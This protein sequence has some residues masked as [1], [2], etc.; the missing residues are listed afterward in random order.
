M[1]NF[2]ERINLLKEQKIT[3][4]HMR[5]RHDQRTHNRWPAG[6]VPQYTPPSGKRRRTA[7]MD[8]YTGKRSS[9]YGADGSAIIS[10]A[11]GSR[12]TSNVAKFTFAN[13]AS[14]VN[15][16]MN[17]STTYQPPLTLTGRDLDEIMAASNN[18]PSDLLIAKH[19]ME[20]GYR[21]NED[22]SA[23]S[24]TGYWAR[25]EGYFKYMD[26]TEADGKLSYQQLAEKSSFFQRAYIAAI[27]KFT[28][29]KT[30]QELKDAYIRAI[31]FADHVEK[32]TAPGSPYDIA[33]NI[34]AL[35][36]LQAMLGTGDTPK[37]L[38]NSSDLN[39]PLLYQLRRLLSVPLQMWEK[40]KPGIPISD[41]P[42][43]DDAFT[44]TYSGN[45]SDMKKNAFDI[46]TGLSNGKT[47]MFGYISQMFPEM[48]TF[49]R[50]LQLMGRQGSES[51]RV[52][53]NLL[54][55]VGSGSPDS[56]P[57]YAPESMYTVDKKIMDEPAQSPSQITDSNDFPI[58]SRLGVRVPA[59]SIQLADAIDPNGLF[60]ESSMATGRSEINSA[61]FEEQTARIRE[62]AESTGVPVNVVSAVMAYWEHGTQTIGNFPIPMLVRLQDAAAE[63]FGLK[64]GEN[65]QRLN[66]YQQELLDE[67]AKIS[68]GGR[69]RGSASNDRET[70]TKVES[71]HYFADP[72]ERNYD[73]FTIKEIMFP[74]TVPNLQETAMPMELRAKV[75]KLPEDMTPE[76]LAEVKKFREETQKYSVTTE[77]NIPG[78]PYETSQQAR[79]AVLKNIYERTQQLLS[80]KGIKRATLYRSVS[81]TKGMLDAVQADIRER[82][83]NQNFSVYNRDGSFNPESLNGVDVNFPRNAMESWTYDLATA[84]LSAVNVDGKGQDGMDPIIAEIVMAADVPASRIVSTPATGFGQY[85]EGEIVITGNKED[86]TKVVASRSRNQIG[87]FK[88]QRFRDLT[89]DGIYEFLKKRFNSDSSAYWYTGYQQLMSVLTQE[90]RDHLIDRRASIIDNALEMDVF[91][92]GMA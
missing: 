17:T 32:L 19:L 14:S 60:A 55:A 42:Y 54:A 77:T 69:Q 6:Y 86:K 37:D 23:E 26:R 68:R 64:L 7:M 83:G 63:L 3:L 82:T 12:R 41:V 35:G 88:K 16:P 28:V 20:R 59:S 52:P 85:N 10:D 87:K 90:Q 49:L 24:R 38:Q 44:T 56:A 92:D 76:V 81:L 40:Y 15:A 11:L 79:M 36:N 73:F 75:G 84:D 46:L 33:R 21:I 27:Q 66:E 47:S 57:T 9:R 8:A 61:K 31:D 25:G 51:M 71:D 4:K 80:E 22:E 70:R 1:K 5:G 18:K 72:F 48:N 45:R 65:D 2:I 58:D 89:L 30:G 50:E 62:I 91:F 34:G 67:A 78:T 29:G 13:R 74:F 53:S 43:F 39:S